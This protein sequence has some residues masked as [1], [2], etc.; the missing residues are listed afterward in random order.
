ML[1]KNMDLG[2]A[3]PYPDMDIWL[4]FLNGWETVKLVLDG[5]N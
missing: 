1:L 5:E 2:E 4:L 3:C